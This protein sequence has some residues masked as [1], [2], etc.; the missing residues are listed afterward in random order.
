MQD[1]Y[2][3][4]ETDRKESHSTNS[5]IYSQRSGEFD[6]GEFLFAVDIDIS[7]DKKDRIEVYTK[8]QPYKL[9]R[10]FCK[11]HGISKNVAELISA[12]IVDTAKAAVAKG[13]EYAKRAPSEE[14]PLGES[15]VFPKEGDEPISEEANSPTLGKDFVGNSGVLT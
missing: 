14:F 2:I 15:Q 1:S 7:S 9:A 13:K 5:T 11:K 3:I 6:R 10:S 4:S 12:K 8:D